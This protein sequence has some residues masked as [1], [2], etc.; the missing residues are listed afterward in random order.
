MPTYI[1]RYSTENSHWNAHPQNLT[2]SLYLALQL[3]FILSFHTILIFDFGTVDSNRFIWNLY[4][5]MNVIN[6]NM[7]IDAVKSLWQWKCLY[8]SFAFVVFWLNLTCKFSK[9]NENL[10][11]YTCIYLQHWKQLLYLKLIQHSLCT[12]AQYIVVSGMHISHV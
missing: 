9:S 5:C 11:P 4:V 2:F 7:Q 10:F 12:N 3:V 6:R 8:I 1:H